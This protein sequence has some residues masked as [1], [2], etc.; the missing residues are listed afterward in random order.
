[1]ALIAGLAD[2]TIDTLVSDHDPKSA[3]VKRL[4]FGQAAEG[5]VGF[6]TMLPLALAQVHAGKLELMTLLRALTS[7]PADLLRLPM[8]RLKEGVQADLVI[9]DPEK[10]WRISQD[11]LVSSAKN[12]PFDTL[13][14]QGQ[15]W[16]TVVAGKP[17][18]TAA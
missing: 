9:F 7:T 10:P 18:Y 16:Q 17:L 15:V 1:M 3:D 5:V 14:V 4:P 12:M 11:D 13:P 6:E 8:G 2:G